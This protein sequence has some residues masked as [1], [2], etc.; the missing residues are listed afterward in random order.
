MTGGPASAALSAAT[1]ARS[2]RPRITYAS[3][4]PRR[5]S[6]SRRR[7]RG[8][9]AA[10]RPRRRRSRDPKDGGRGAGLRDPE[11]GPERELGEAWGRGRGARLPRPWFELTLRPTTLQ[12]AV[13]RVLSLKT[14]PEGPGYSPW[15]L[16]VAVRER[17][18][19][20][21]G[22]VCSCVHLFLLPN[23]NPLHP[24]PRAP[25]PPAI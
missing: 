22:D 15:G 25:P 23:H 3:P 6:A 13:L 17:K 7:R 24:P 18:R 1:P 8:R 9:C 4:E 11:E 19:R 14:Y 20:R 21:K 5:W 12:G 16:G 10:C 2:A